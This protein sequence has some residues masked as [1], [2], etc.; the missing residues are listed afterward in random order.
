MLSAV[1]K[2]LIE[3]LILMNDKTGLSEF[4]QFA[5]SKGKVRDVEEAFKDYTVE[6]EWHKGKIENITP[7]NL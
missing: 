7:I 1:K 3:E 4:M 6:N 5:Y 2:I